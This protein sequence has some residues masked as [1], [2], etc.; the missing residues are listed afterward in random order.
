MTSKENTL[1][2]DKA[3]IRT[4]LRHMLGLTDRK[5]KLT[6]INMVMTKGKVR[7]HSRSDRQFQ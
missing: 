1:W 3:I 4:S 2:E 6:M 5:L 7:E